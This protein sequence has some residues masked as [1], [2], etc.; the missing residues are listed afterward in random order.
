MAAEEK[1]NFVRPRIHTEPVLQKRL[2]NTRFHVIMAVTSKL[3][4]NETPCSL[5]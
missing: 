2:I 1:V 3:F 4:W 5:V